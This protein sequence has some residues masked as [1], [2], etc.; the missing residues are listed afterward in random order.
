MGELNFDLAGQALYSNLESF[1]LTADIGLPTTRGLVPGSEPAFDGEQF[2]VNF[3]GI[4]AGAPS[5][6]KGGI[7]WI[8]TTMMFFY[9]WDVVILRGVA[10]QSGQGKRGGIPGSNALAADFTK[11]A[12]DGTALIEAL[13][14][15]HSEYLIVPYGTPFQYG[16]LKPVAAE[17]GLSGVSC[18]VTFQAGMSADGTY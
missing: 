11:L 12:A 10:V 8:P 6:A 2:T 3:T 4:T 1:L 13:L 7:V 9:E 14:W 17:G 5:A 15:L 18:P 16:P